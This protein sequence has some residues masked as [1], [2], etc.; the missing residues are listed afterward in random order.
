[1]IIILAAFFIVHAFQ[2][3]FLTPLYKY[4]EEEKPYDKIE[5]D[6]ESI[7]TDVAKS[8]VN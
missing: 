5:E 8:Q 6:F 7:G 3:Y 4:D 1:M 2:I